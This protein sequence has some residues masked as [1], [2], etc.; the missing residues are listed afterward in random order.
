MEIYNSFLSKKNGDT[1]KA[2]QELSK[3]LGADVFHYVSVEIEH[4]EER[5]RKA[6]Q[7]LL[8]NKKSFNEWLSDDPAVDS[9][10]EQRSFNEW[11]SDEKL[12]ACKIKLFNFDKTQKLK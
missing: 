8:E 2:F 7:E 4:H 5:A 9:T 12:R 11:L 3:E 1:K 10:G 6:Y